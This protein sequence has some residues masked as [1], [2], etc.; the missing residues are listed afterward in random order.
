MEEDGDLGVSDMT[1][2]YTL[3]SKVLNKDRSCVQCRR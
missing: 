2:K 3:M 1:Q